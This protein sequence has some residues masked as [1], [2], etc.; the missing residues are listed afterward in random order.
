MIPKNSAYFDQKELWALCKEK[1]EIVKSLEEKLTRLTGHDFCLLF[2]RGRTAFYAL[3]RSEKV[4]GKEVV[5]PSYTCMV[6]PNSVLSS[7]NFLN[8]QDINLS[9]FNMNLLQLKGIKKDSFLV[10]THFF[11]NPL[12]VALLKKKYPHN[13]ILEDCA[14]ALGSKFNGQKVGLVGDAALFSFGHNKIISSFLGGMISTNERKIYQRLANYVQQEMKPPT[15]ITTANRFFRFLFSYTQQSPFLSTGVHWLS[16]NRTFKRL[17][18]DRDLESTALPQDNLELL[19]L[20]QKKVLFPQILK[21]D[22]IIQKRKAYA[23]YYY[24]K[25]KD[26]EGIYVPPFNPDSVYSH[27][28]VLVPNRDKKGVTKKMVQKGVELGEMLNYHIAGMKLYQS[29]G[30]SLGSSFESHQFPNSERAGRE[31]INLPNYPS[32]NWKEVRSIAEKFACV[33]E[34]SEKEWHEK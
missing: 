16:K 3:L 1:E 9:D 27:F 7:Q 24:E 18:E 29:L 2:P 12:D 4:L 15:L 14:L 17:K 13:F 33:L 21:L 32:L 31:M 5:L 11:G 22:E 23:R 8:L 28:P 34:E 10:P 19:S 20:F 6:M 25:F 26:N 30:Q